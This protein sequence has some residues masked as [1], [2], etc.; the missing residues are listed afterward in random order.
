LQYSYSQ[1]HTTFSF[2]YLEDGRFFVTHK[3]VSPDVNFI[4]IFIQKFNLT[5]N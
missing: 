2:S 1:Q 4:I 5:I 3:F